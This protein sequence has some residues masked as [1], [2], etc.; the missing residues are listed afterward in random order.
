MGLIRLVYL[1]LVIYSWLIVARALF[2]WFPVQPG[3]PAYG[4]QRFLVRVTEPYLSIFRRVLPVTRIGGVGIDWSA[5][6]GLIVLLL[7]LQVFGR[8]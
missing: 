2:S 8:L 1:A 6:V 4:V 3:S 5:L 7:V